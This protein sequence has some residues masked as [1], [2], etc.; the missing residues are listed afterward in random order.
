MQYLSKE[1]KKLYQVED[2]DFFK[3]CLK[4]NKNKS[5]KNHQKEYV[6]SLRKVYFK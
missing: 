4:N 6:K 3:W 5:N 1:I 2:N